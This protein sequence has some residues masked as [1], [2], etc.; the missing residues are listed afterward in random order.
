MNDLMIKLYDQA[1]IIEGNDDY[2]SGELDPVLFA[3]LIIKECAELLPID[4]QVAP[5][6]QPIVNIFKEHFGIEECQ[7]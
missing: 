2:V 3:Q 6:G 5:N 4:M 7:Q 1:L